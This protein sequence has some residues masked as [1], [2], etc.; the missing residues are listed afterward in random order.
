LSSPSSFNTLACGSWSR[1]TTTATTVNKD[2]KTIMEEGR[3]EEEVDQ[4]EKEERAKRSP[5]L[6]EKGGKYHAEAYLKP[7]SAPHSSY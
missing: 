5:S 7:F 4:R 2:M 6:H 1:A 3:Q